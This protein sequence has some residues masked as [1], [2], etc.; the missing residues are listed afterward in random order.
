MKLTKAQQKKLRTLANSSMG[1]FMIEY[2]ELIKDEAADVRNKLEVKPEIEN[3][4]RKAVC[5]LLD[6][7]LIQK[8]NVLNGQSSVDIEDYD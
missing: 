2:A 3:E 1:K 7:Y 8:L 6:T 4:V 5:E